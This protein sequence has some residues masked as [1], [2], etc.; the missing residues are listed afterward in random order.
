MIEYKTGNL[1]VEPVEALVNTVNCVGVMGRGVALQFKNKYAQN[2]KAYAVACKQGEVQPGQMFVV[3]IS[4]LTNPRYIINF[5]TKRHWRGK[6]RIEDIQSGLLALAQEV[7][8]RNIQSL[9]LPPLG[10]GLGGLPWSEV[11][12]LIQSVFANL[13]NVQ[14]VV[15]EPSAEHETVNHNIS[16]DVPKMTPGRAAL[17]ALMKRYLDGLLDPF[18]SLLEVHKLMYFLQEAKQPLNL[19]YVKGYYGPYSENLGKVLQKIEGHMISGYANGG[20]EP[21]KQLTIVPKASDD[22]VAFLENYPEDTSRFDRVANLVEGFETPFGLELLATVH[23]VVKEENAVS[24]E[25]ALQKVYAWNSRK[26]QFSE[27]QIQLAYQTL[28][29][30][31]WFTSDRLAG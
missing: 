10:C 28:E 27:R 11:K 6:S 2:Y 16:T 30:K 1:L 14:V 15:F 29:E 31:G 20:D 8:D 4:Q 12:P 13:P 22:A 21:T 26:K 25:D 17:V 9:A 3:Q 7:T 23:W 19:R 18:I 5:P 24:S